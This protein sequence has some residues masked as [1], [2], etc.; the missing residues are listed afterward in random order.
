LGLDDNLRGE[1]YLLKMAITLG[2]IGKALGFTRNDNIDIEPVL[3]KAKIFTDMHGIKL[4]LVY[5][6]MRNANSVQGTIREKIL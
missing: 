3:K 6:P 5:I 1:L 4:F 2:N